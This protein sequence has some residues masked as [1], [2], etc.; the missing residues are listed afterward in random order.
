M[1]VDYSAYNSVSSFA[2][3]HHDGIVQDFTS[4]DMNV[5]LP[6]ASTTAFESSPIFIDSVSRKAA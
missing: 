5:S 1:N 2:S 3:M 4:V 6:I